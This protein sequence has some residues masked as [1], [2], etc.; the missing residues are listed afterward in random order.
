MALDPSI[1]LR[2][3][4]LDVVGAMRQG[5]AAA[6]ETNQMRQQN[7]LA[8][9]YQTQGA[10]LL[11]GDQGALN[12]L[13]GVDPAA[14]F[15]MRGAQ[16]DF[17]MNARKME[18]LNAEEKRAIADAAAQMDAAQK[19]A[20][21]AQT[22]KSVFQMI[23]AP[24][25]EAFD[26]MAQAA[27]KP[28]LVGQFENRKMLGAQYITEV[29]DLFKLV[30]GPEA[31]KPLSGQGKFAA[32]QAAGFIP[33]DATY[34]S[35]GTTVNMGGGSDK[36]IFDTLV[37]DRDIARSVVSGYAGLAEAK[38]AVDSGI[39]SGFGA[40]QVLALQKVGAAIGV[41]DPT[42]IQNTET[43]RSAIAPQVAAMLKA[44]AGTA[45][46]SNAD[47]EFAEKAA[48]GNINLDAGTIKR[49]LGIMET[50]ARTSIEGYQRKLDAIY[51]DTPQFARERAIFAIPAPDF[52][53]GSSGL[54]EQTDQA[55]STPANIPTGALDLLKQNN[56]PEYRQFF[57]E[58]FGAGAAAQILG[59]N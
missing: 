30:D 35:G 1:I 31:P 38:K 32:D 7:A 9:V 58:V 41:A 2:G 45:N 48:G 14:A 55:G 47:R 43:F 53:A 3:Q 37:A 49:L 57:D 21:I 4:P 36:Q 34:D 24:T 42:I 19:E 51:P 28:E 26:Q 54:P 17:Q 59:G 40:D 13:A 22:R 29:S 52:S 50:A 46:L 16:Q 39:I 8:N 33:P 25:P 18:I 6:M 20:A 44:T 56:T 11:A 10:G 23:A 5:N 27:G 12:A 15:N